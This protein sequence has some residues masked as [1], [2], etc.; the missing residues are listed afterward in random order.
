MRLLECPRLI[1]IKVLAVFAKS[2]IEFLIYQRPGVRM[3]R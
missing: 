1:C 2:G 3:M